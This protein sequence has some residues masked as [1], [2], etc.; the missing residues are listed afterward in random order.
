MA[1]SIRLEYSLGQ[2]VAKSNE[3]PKKWRDVKPDEIDITKPMVL[4][5][6]GNGTVTNKLANGYAKA[7]QSILGVD[8]QDDFV[9]IF[10]LHYGGQEDASIG[11]VSFEE[12]EELAKGIF[13]RRVVDENGERLPFD[14]AC[15][16]MRNV[17]IVTYSFGANVLKHLME[18]TAQY[19]EYNLGY[20]EDEIS[21]ILKQVLQVCYA[22]SVN[23]MP[24]STNFVVKSLQDRN[25]DYSKEYQARFGV[26]PIAYGKVCTNENQVVL[27]V[28]QLSDKAGINEHDI[29]LLRRPQNF[30]TENKRANTASLCVGYVLSAGILNSK[31]NAESDK[32]IPLLNQN[33][34]FDAVKSAIDR[35]NEIAK[36]TDKNNKTLNK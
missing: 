26:Q 32:F 22:P 4:C 28:N 18:Q 25:F 14:D 23:D 13:I 24:F 34:I 17:N 5:L 1:S 29:T 6:G 35:E 16:N 36:Y 15:K 20:D 7:V 27:Y 19:M 11:N 12:I 10:S 21:D 3:Y 30:L 2:R 9:D 33:E 8:T 31:E